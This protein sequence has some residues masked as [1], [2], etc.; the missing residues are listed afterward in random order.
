MIRF[1]SIFAVIAFCISCF[2]FNTAIT[3][4]PTTYEDS[5]RTIYSQP[6]SQWPKPNVDS[7]VDWVELGQL[8]NPPLQKFRDSLKPLIE[9]GKL[10]FF[11]PRLSV[12]NQI[13]CGSC[14]V[15]D[16]NW[17]DGRGQAVG[18]DRTL[19]R[20]NTPSI[21][22]VWF[23]KKLFWDGRANSL[24]DQISG[25]ISGHTEMNQDMKVLAEKL[26]AVAGYEPIFKAAYG[27]TKVTNQRIIH[28]L[29]TF[30][31][32]ITSQRTKFDAFLDGKQNS[33]SDAQIRGLNLFRTKANCM[34]C[35][36]GPLFTDGGFHNIGLSLLGRPFEDLG[37][38]NV[39][40]D[41]VDLG[42]FKTP[43][44]RSVMRTRPWMHN[45]FFDDIEGLIAFYNN[46]NP[47]GI[48]RDSLNKSIPTP[49]LDPHLHKL[50]LT[51]NEMADIALFLEAI[52]AAPNL[53]REPQLPK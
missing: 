45:G 4:P 49:K 46:G 9:L 6:S 50:H 36:N 38:Y 8:P 25:P 51:R 15:P 39:T 26:Q 7:G 34:N 47:Q 11:D 20:R 41:T 31:G 3:T 18:H 29:A 13:A 21:E 19:N 2:C 35:H 53:V 37:R 1:V 27:D 43:S 24:E 12:S 17:T 44:L 52:T 10:L 30:E 40:K 28:A 22:N 33:L 23:F 5:L 14:H 16:L 32:T 42:K 48:R